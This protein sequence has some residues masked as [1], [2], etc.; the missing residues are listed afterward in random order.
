MSIVKEHDGQVKTQEDRRDDGTDNEI[1]G[2]D[3][4]K[5]YNADGLAKPP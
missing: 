1:D 2:D 5:L 4:I 3:A